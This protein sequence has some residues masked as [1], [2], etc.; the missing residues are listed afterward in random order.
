MEYQLYSTTMGSI[1]LAIFAGSCGGLFCVDRFEGRG[2]LI[3]DNHNELAA[4]KFI[5]EEG[6]AYFIWLSGENFCHLGKT[7]G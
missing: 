5:A 7:T 1:E 2:D 4:R 3:W 6:K